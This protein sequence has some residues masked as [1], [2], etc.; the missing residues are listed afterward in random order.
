MPGAH[1]SRRARAAATACAAALLVALAADPARA[2]RSGLERSGPLGG[3]VRRTP[4]DTLHRLERLERDLPASASIERGRADCELEELRRDAARAERAA[5][6]RSP[7]APGPGLLEADRSGFPD[8]RSLSDPAPVFGTAKEWLRV[9]GL[10]GA[11]E[12]RFQRSEHDR[13]RFLTEQVRAGLAALR[14]RLPADDPQVRAA[15]ARLGALRAGLG[16]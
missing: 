13:A 9:E 5:R 10:L 3:D 7:A 8:R 6:D 16:G 1:R 14:S 2:Q 15:E 12:T 4:A 11:A